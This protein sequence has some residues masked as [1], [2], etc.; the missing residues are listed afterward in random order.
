MDGW[1]MGGGMYGW[2]DLSMIDQ[3]MDGWMGGW[4]GLYAFNWMDGWTD[5][6]MNK[7]LDGCFGWATAQWGCS[8]SH[9]T[10]TK[11]NCPII[12]LDLQPHRYL[13]TQKYSA[14]SF[15]WHQ[16][17]YPSTKSCSAPEASYIPFLTILII[18]LCAD[19][20]ATVTRRLHIVRSDQ[21]TIHHLLY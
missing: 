5:L 21:R 16:H 20:S 3:W 13:H 14:V 4:I 15:Y 7:W 1:W 10:S 8:S 6:L 17:N 18:C 12:Q 2:N 9:T 19:L 11:K